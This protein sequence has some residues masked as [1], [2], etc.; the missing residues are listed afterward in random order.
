MTTITVDG[1]A[2]DYSGLPESH[3]D[4]MK[5]YIEHGYQP[6][7]GWTAILHNDLRAVVM[8]DAET[9][10][11]LPRIYRWLVN[12]A[13]SG[14]W[15]SPEKVTEWMRSRRAARK[16]AACPWCGAAPCESPS[17][18]RRQARMEEDPWEADNHTALDHE[19]DV[20]RYR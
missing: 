5:L 2:V 14:C 11:A 10:A 7:S 13:P 9:A 18:C 17:A 4:T 16:P 6:G 12:H 8:V 20:E 1:M 19:T 3:Q 15:G